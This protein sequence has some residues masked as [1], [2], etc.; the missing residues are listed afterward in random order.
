MASEKNLFVEISKAMAEAVS[1]AEK[2]TVLVNARRRMPS[3]GIVYAADL[4]LTAD[5]T[6]ERDDE[7]SVVLPN[8]EQIS[9]EIAGRDP[10]SDLTLLRLS[11]AKAVP[12]AI[13]NEEARVGEFVLALGRPKT[14]GIEASLGVISAINGPVRTRRGGT[15]EK[16]IRTDAIPMPGFSGGPLV[17]AEGKVLGLN[18]SGLSHSLLLSIPV[19]MTWKVAQA[20]EEHGSIK[21]GFLGIQSQPVEISGEAADALERDQVSGLLL[22]HIETGS[23]SEQGGLMVGDIIIGMGGVPV[24][25]HDT[26]LTR[27]SGDV[28]GKATPVEVLRG[29]LVK[30]VEVTVEERQPRPQ[31]RGRH[32][33][34]SHRRHHSR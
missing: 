16:F 23:P 1:T 25:D 13:A 10:G 26:L 24:S 21:R 3:S 12:A 19:E 4:V 29:G 20:L 2:A 30:I 14:S 17:N 33:R 18:T 7:I 32:G 22:T 27:I 9:A 6:V 11:E 5:H 8:G 31:R 34:K 28:V 15:I